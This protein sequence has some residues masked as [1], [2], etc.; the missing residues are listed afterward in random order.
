MKRK[1]ARVQDR[2]KSAEPTASPGFT[3]RAQ[4][5]A[6]SQGRRMRGWR[7]PS[8]GPNQATVG[9][10]TIRNRTRDAVRNDWGAAAGARSWIT[11][12]IGSGI[13]P[14]PKTDNQKL[15]K[16]LVELWDEWAPF[17]DAD[18]VLDFYGLQTLATRSWITAGEVFIRFR[19]RRLDDGL[20]VRSRSS[21]SS[22]TWCPLWTL[23]VGQAW[24]RAT[25]CAKA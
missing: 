5:E 8:T 3:A 14:R 11:N 17:A 25:V 24:R 10:E 21:C 4:Y 15:K 6:A 13:V 23:I 2:V 1:N 7:T 18:G 20:Q 16:R 19:Y 22:P 9:L 12:L